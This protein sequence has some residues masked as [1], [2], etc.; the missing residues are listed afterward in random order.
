MEPEWQIRRDAFLAALSA[1]P[2][3]MGILNVTP[4]SFSDGG[5]FNAFD[6]AMAQ[7]T[8][9]EAEG[10]DILDIGGESTRPGATAVAAEE[11]LQ[12]VLPVISAL[13]EKSEVP[14]SIDTYK[15]QVA[16]AAIEAGAVI[17]NDVWGLQK[18]P[19]M[20]V[21]VAEAGAAVI[22]MHNRPFVDGSIDIMA[23]MRAYLD[24]S[25]EIAARAGVAEARILVDPG[26]G[27]GKTPDQ[28]LTCIA[29]LSELSDWYGLPVLL[30]LSRKRFIGHV[31]G[32]DVDDRLTGTLAANMSGLENG[33]RVLRVHDVKPHV[34]A[35]KLT[36]AIK[37]A[38]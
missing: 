32:N 18:D 33:A 25:L 20:A 21:A 38:I 17:V 10:C 6:Q 23:D 26:I 34:E 24:R 31:L 5:Q 9:M 27:F 35:V 37:A 4:D 3:V 14:I 8:R 13:F 12:R 2:L 15:A 16:R 19:E 22:V 30:G 1:R 11:E 28:S 29:R 36:E 7:G